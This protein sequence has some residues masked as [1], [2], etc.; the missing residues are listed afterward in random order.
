[1][2]CRQGR[3][4]IPRVGIVFAS[5]EEVWEVVVL[6]VEI[7]LVPSYRTSDEMPRTGLA[8]TDHRFKS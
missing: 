3:G 1:M 7:F 8:S 2:Q 5:F 6:V 4:S